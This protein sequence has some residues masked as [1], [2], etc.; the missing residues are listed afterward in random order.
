MLDVPFVE[1]YDL[2]EPSAIL[3]RSDVFPEHPDTVACRFD[4]S[5]S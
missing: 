5:L 4:L 2:S 1:V 3:L